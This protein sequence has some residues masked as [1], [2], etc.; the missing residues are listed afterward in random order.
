MKSKKL[1]THEVAYGDSGK[2]LKIRDN[3]VDVDVDGRIILKLTLK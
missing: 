2:N 3:W 1:G